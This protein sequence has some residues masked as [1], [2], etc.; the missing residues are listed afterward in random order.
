MNNPVPVPFQFRSRP[1]PVLFQQRSPSLEEIRAMYIEAMVEG[2]DHANPGEQ[3]DF[4]LEQM[5]AAELTRVGMSYLAMAE[6]KL[7]P[8]SENPGVTRVTQ[9]VAMDSAA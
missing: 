1:V 7:F 5:T 2:C 6:W 8:G 3:F 4:D 9:G